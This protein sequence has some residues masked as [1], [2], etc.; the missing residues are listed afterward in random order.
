MDVV[1][2]ND[3]KFPIQNINYIDKNIY[4]H[5]NLEKI[6]VDTSNSK[7]TVSTRMPPSYP[8]TGQ[9]KIKRAKLEF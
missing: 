3:Q 1:S 7:N 9:R 4:S 5:K 6:T 8:T 2:A